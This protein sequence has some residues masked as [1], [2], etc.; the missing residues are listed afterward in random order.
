MKKIIFLFVII[1][2]QL[3]IINSLVFA[4]K[5]NEL[6]GQKKKLQKEIQYTQGLLSE[7]KKNKKLSLNQLLTLNKQID[8][9]EELIR[10]ISAEIKILNH[11]INDN[12]EIIETMQKDLKTLKNDYAKMIYY[13]HK[14]QNSYHRLSF[15]FS[16]KD[17]NQAYQRLKYMQQYSGFRRKQAE[18]I[19][20][21]QNILDKKTQELEEKKQ[22]KKNL[23]TSE[24]LEKE[25]LAHEK[26]EQES[27]LGGLQKQ[28]KELIA[29]LKEKE[30]EQ[31]QL[32]MAIQRI[33]EEEIMRAKESAEKSG[34]SAPV[35]L[36]LTPEALK[37]SANFASN[38]AQLPWPVAEGVIT[39][40][41]GEHP[42]PVLKKVVIKN[43]GIDISTKPGAEV[44]AI[45]DG[46]ITG[47]A[48]VLGFGNVVMIR[49]GE[50]LSVYSN[51]KEVVVKKG[52]KISTKQTV[53]IVDTD[54]TNSKT[55]VH[56]EIWK[57]SNVL[58]PE[59]WLYR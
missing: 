48:T 22:E 1:N 57:G 23:L 53:G 54:E 41:F 43:N 6:E 3:S 24:E 59:V 25:N 51:L 35:G 33:I 2:C 44:R 15:V 30:K 45:F 28:E 21:T 50:Y 32:Q 37:L 17:F 26:S 12:R 18:L 14:N 13:A 39:A 19:L 49:H 52:D 42:H 31:K 9:R 34:K 40:K 56:F 5:K 16:S 7:T 58:N 4:Q 46:E 36:A 27:V 10:T 47:I 8:I 38:K 20:E 11:Q 29:A 55:E